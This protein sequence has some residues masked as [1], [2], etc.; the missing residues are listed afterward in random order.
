MSYALQIKNLGKVYSN[1][2]RALKGVSF[3]IKKGEFFALLGPNGSG[4][5]T[6]INI[7][8]GPTKKSSGQVKV[9]GLDIDSHRQQTKMKLGVV[10]QEINFDPFFTVTEALKFQAGYYGAKFD[11]KYASEI[12]ENLGLYDQRNTISRSLSGGM[13][14]RLLIAKA[15]IHKPEVL[16]LDEPTAGVDV[17]LRYSLW[18][19]IRQLNREGMT[20]LLTTHYLEE[21]ESLCKRIAIINEGELI[22]LEKTKTLTRS[23][24]NKKRLTISA[25]NRITTIPPA[26]KPFNPVKIS[27]HELV[28]ECEAAHLKELLQALDKSKLEFTDIDMQSSKLEDVFIKLTHK[29]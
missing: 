14:R 13:K 20:I 26:L 17:E 7:T 21:A 4:K 28:I 24:G 10:P 15:L 8:A 29:K 9:C 5:S 2:T 11:P 3:D 22:A 1:G 23:M 18:K 6:L 27:K 16:V 12:L 25:T 19:Y